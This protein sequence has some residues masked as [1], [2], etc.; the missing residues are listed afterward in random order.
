VF[1][2]ELVVKC[3]LLLIAPWWCRG[4]GIVHT[5]L[6]LQ[7]LREVKCMLSPLPIHGAGMVRTEMTRAYWNEA[8]IE[9]SESAAG[10]IARADELDDARS[11]LFFHMSGERLPW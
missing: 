5:K 10:L 2:S 11:G 6:T 4:A 9:A 7:H 8:C 3:W 1:S